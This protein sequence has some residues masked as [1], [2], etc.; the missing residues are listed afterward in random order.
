MLFLLKDAVIFS[1]PLCLCVSMYYSITLILQVNSSY[2]NPLPYYHRSLHL[3]YHQTLLP[4]QQQPNQQ[5]DSGKSRSSSSTN[6]CPN[7]PACTFCRS[8]CFD[9]SFTFSCSSLSLLLVLVSNQ[10]FDLT[11]IFDWIQHHLDWLTIHKVLF[12]N[13]SSFI[14]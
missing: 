7:Q 12:C 11:M 13:L 3:D 8:D 5:R 4:N 10:V 2:L 6:T 1:L 14:C 9:T